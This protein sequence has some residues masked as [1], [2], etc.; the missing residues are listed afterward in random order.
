M[1]S[2][3]DH[4]SPW[5]KQGFLCKP[6]NSDRGDGLRFATEYLDAAGGIDADDAWSHAHVLEGRDGGGDAAGAP[7][8]GAAA[9]AVVHAGG[10]QLDRDKRLRKVSAKLLDHLGRLGHRT[11]QGWGGGRWAE[12]ARSKDR[13]ASAPRGSHRPAGRVGGSVRGFWSCK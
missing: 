12:K 4:Y 3:E 8:L 13:R 2:Q 11:L 5:R 9:T 7:V 10:T 1:L 6:W